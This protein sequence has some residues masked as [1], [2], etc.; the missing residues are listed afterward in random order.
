MDDGS[1]SNRRT[2]QYRT[3]HRLHFIATAG[4]VTQCDL[5]LGAV[6][7]DTDFA[8]A[9][10]WA[11]N[12]FAASLNGGA[13]VTDLAGTNPLGMTIARIGYGVSNDYFW[14]STIKAIETRRTASNAELPL[15]AA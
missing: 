7:A 9:V 10:R 1:S 2:L 13:I 14:N 15:L 4:G 6:A 12:N 5:D 3:D 8:V 11:D